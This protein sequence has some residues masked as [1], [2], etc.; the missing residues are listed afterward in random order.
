MK[1]IEDDLT[2]DAVIALLD[3]HFDGMHEVSPPGSCHVMDHATLREEGVTVWTAWEGEELLGSG[4]LKEIDAGHGEVKSMRTAQAHL[5]KGVGSAI[6]DHVIAVARRRGYRRLSLETGSSDDFAAS[7]A[8]YTR[9][10]FR[11]CEPFADYRKDP[12]SYFM[13]LELEPG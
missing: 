9:Y 11:A 1:I 12:F 6:L 8:L 2:H 5:R 7:R 4:A 13:T 3:D 10:G